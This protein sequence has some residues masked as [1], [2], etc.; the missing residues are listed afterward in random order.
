MENNNWENE[1][2]KYKQ[3]SALNMPNVSTRLFYKFGHTI[4]DR[5]LAECHLIE[6]KNDKLKVYFGKSKKSTMTA[7]LTH[8]FT[9]NVC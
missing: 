2:L 7:K 5:N 3:C 6:M 8:F 9:L 1:K 4:R